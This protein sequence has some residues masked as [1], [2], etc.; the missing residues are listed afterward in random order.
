MELGRREVLVGLA[1]TAV[2]VGGFAV[3]QA[4]LRARDRSSHLPFYGGTA[5]AV[6]SDHRRPEQ[7]DTRIVW[8]GDTEEKVVALT[9]DDG[10]APHWT[11]SVLDAL[12]AEDVRATFFVLG[13]HVE[14]HPDLLRRVASHHHDVGNHTF[15]HPDLARLDE[16]AVHDELV[17]CQRAVRRVIG[18]NPALFRPPYGHLNGATLVAAN[19]LGLTLVLWSVQF[20]EEQHL[21]NPGGIVGAVAEAAHPGAIVLGHDSGKPRRRISIDH[22]RAIIGR[23]RADGYR[24]TTVS[25]LLRSSS[26]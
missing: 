20:L 12:A 24:F 7:P 23:L 18:R 21:R 22:L 10:P 4:E 8:R 17:R 11:P 16:R 1:G 9:F 19:E 15:D 3:A 26:T 25:E 5:S 6:P 2:G 14:E 13:R